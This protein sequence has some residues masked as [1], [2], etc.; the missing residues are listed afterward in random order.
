MR[1]IIPVLLLSCCMLG[2]DDVPRPEHV[3]A[4]QPLP[5]YGIHTVEHDGCEWVVLRTTHGV[6]IQHHPQCHC[7][8]GVEF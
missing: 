4:S 6:A 7:V 2:C 1:T 8:D 3:S 5:A